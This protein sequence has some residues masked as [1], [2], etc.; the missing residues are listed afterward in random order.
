MSRRRNPIRPE[1]VIVT[2]KNNRVTGVPGR[3]DKD[4]MHIFDVSAMPPVSRAV[5]KGMF[6][7]S[8]IW[9]LGDAYSFGKKLTT[10]QIA[11]LIAFLKQSK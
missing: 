5:E 8:T 4:S 9:P 7:A 2:V 10:K 1:I 3:E 6:K 11:D